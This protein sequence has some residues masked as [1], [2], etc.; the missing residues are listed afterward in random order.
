MRKSSNYAAYNG[1]LLHN[2]ASLSDIFIIARIKND[3]DFIIRM[4]YGAF[5]NLVKYL[6]IISM[7]LLKYDRFKYIKYHSEPHRIYYDG[8]FNQMTATMM[9]NTF[10]K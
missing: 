8:A 2:A 7:P 9:L 1:V 6:L 10:H 5:H 4:A 3:I